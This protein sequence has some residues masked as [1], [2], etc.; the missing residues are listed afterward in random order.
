MVVGVQF[1]HKTRELVGSFEAQ[2]LNKRS[3]FFF[4]LRGGGGD[5]GRTADGAQAPHLVSLLRSFWGK[6]LTFLLQNTKLQHCECS[7]LEVA[8]SQWCVTT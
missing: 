1:L 4:L 7:Q 5:G 6:R 8:S 2:V 3:T